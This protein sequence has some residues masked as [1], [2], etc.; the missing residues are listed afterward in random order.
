MRNYK[1]NNNTSLKNEE[2]NI[3]NNNSNALRIFDVHK[4]YA[5]LPL[6]SN[7]NECKKKNY[8]II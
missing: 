2:N 1:D 5:K 3:N 4:A 6:T 7:N 8:I